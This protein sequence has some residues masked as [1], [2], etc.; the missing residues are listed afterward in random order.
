LG[1]S[2]DEQSFE[3]RSDDDCKRKVNGICLRKEPEG[4]SYCHYGCR[5]DA[6]CEANQLCWCDYPVA[7][8]VSARCRSDDDCAGDA[9]CGEYVPKDDCNGVAYACQTPED[10][11]AKKSCWQARG[12]AV[13][14]CTLNEGG[15]RVCSSGVKCPDR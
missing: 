2:S 10:E 5:A 6:D 4:G 12:E 9:V 14:F 11:C 15:R 1:A 8:C 13:S 3:C 7:R